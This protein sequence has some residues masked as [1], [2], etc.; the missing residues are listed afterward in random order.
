[1]Q[2][3]LKIAH[4]DHSY[5]ERR[6]GHV[7]YSYMR[8]ASARGA[9]RRAALERAFA[10]WLEVSGGDQRL[11]SLS[12]LGLIVMQRAVLAA[13]DLG[14]LLVALDDTPQDLQIRTNKT[15]APSPP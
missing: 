15:R 5:V 13:E 9:Y 12:G 11:P 4:H 6:G 14:R 3:A 8:Q 2:L 10:R 1:M 7:L